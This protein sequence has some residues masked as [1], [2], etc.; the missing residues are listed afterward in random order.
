M[1]T[2]EVPRLSCLLR[3]TSLA[4]YLNGIV[5]FDKIDYPV[6]INLAIRKRK[7]ATEV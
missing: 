1:K 3:S 5:N 4:S 7:N 2:P 6:M